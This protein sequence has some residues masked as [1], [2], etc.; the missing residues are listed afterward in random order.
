MDR[1][2]QRSIWLQSM[3]YEIWQD[4]FCPRFKALVNELCADNLSNESKTYEEETLSKH[5]ESTDGDNEDDSVDNIELE[6]VDDDDSDDGLECVHDAGAEENTNDSML[7][8]MKE[9]YPNYDPF[10][11]LE[12][13]YTWIVERH[14][15]NTNVLKYEVNELKSEM[16]KLAQK[17]TIS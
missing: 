8:V 2:A 12:D 6:D 13:A 17:C 7:N 3:W 11:K 9:W 15:E 1:G 16:R 5:V 10:Q 14:A 4:D